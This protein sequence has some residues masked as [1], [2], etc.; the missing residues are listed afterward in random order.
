MSGKADYTQTFKSGFKLDAG[1]KS[2]LVKTDNEANYYNHINGDWVADYDKTNHF[3]YEENINAGYL[4]GQKKMGKF[5]TQL[6][7]RFENTNY[8]GNQLGNPVKADSTFSRSYN[9][10]FPTAYITYE[11]DSSNTFSIN[12][13]RRINRP[14]YQQLNPFLFF[15][16]QYTYQEG[17]PYLQPEFTWNIELGHVYKNWLTTT[18]GYSYTDQ[19]F[20]Q[21]FRTEGEVTILTMGNLQN[22][23]NLSLAINAQLKPVK[24]WWSM[25]VQLTTAYTQVNGMSLD[26]VIDTKA[27]NGQIN[28]NNQFKFTK[29]W[30]A[31]LSGFYNSKN[32]DGQFTIQAF[33]QVTAGVSKTIL[34]EKGTLKFNIRDIFYGQV[35]D[36]RIDYQNVVEHFRQSRDSRVANL[37]FTYRFGKTFSETAKKTQW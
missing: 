20:S 37:A 6:G 19:V 18:L 14:A 25:N 29:G 35:I 5:N 27:F 33:S 13:G 9:S 10:L 26:D 28:V 24:K 1:W 8:T 31:E 30:S 2:S 11:K 23:K 7:L 3:I 32:Q 4:N 12:V 34:K 36:G 22:R 21:I 17:N 16:N 15:I